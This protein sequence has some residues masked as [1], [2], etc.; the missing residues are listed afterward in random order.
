LPSFIPFEG[1]AHVP[2]IHDTACPRLKST[3][4]A[5]EL[6]DDGTIFLVPYGFPDP[7]WRE[8]YEIGW[9]HGVA[10]TARL[11]FRLWQITREIAW[12]GIAE[13]AA[14]SIMQSGVPDHPRSDFAGQ[15]LV[16]IDLRFGMAGAADFLLSLYRHKGDRNYLHFARILMHEVLKKSV[17]EASGRKWL[18]TRFPFMENSG[19]LAA[20]TGY[21]YGAAG[22]GL[23]LTRAHA[24]ERGK[25]Y[26]VVFPDDPFSTTGRKR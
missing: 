14:R 5:Q 24:A 12:L 16:R 10:G 19:E 22:Y 20:F 25:P 7:A 8:R 2:V 15:E 17:V 23:L 21:F 9:A 13:A 4:S 1:D 26:L 11:F 18:E 6:S 3:L